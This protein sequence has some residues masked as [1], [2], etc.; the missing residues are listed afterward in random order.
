[1]IRLSRLGSRGANIVLRAGGLLMGLFL[2]TRFWFGTS[3]G[4]GGGRSC[5]ITSAPSFLRFSAASRHVGS[6]VMETFFC[7]R[8]FCRVFI[9]FP[10]ALR[11]CSDAHHV[12]FS[13]VMLSFFCV[14]LPEFPN[15]CVYALYKYLLYFGTFAYARAFSFAEEINR[16]S[17]DPLGY[18][19][20]Q[21]GSAQSGGRRRLHNQGFMRYMFICLRCSLP[22]RVFYRFCG[23]VFRV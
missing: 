17:V 12:V 13:P 8:C 4:R 22:T 23:G 16:A 6:C 20:D 21:D 1:M 18:Q 11:G 14:P 10:F 7:V 15:W 3:A 5:K 2:S 19:S 9:F